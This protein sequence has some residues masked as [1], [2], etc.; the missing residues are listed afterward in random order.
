M[1][2]VV[3]SSF[4]AP[5]MNQSGEVTPKESLSLSSASFTFSLIPLSFSVLS[6]VSL[7]H[8]VSP[9]HRMTQMFRTVSRTYPASERLTALYLLVHPRFLILYVIPCVLLEYIIHSFDSFYLCGLAVRSLSRKFELKVRV[10]Q[11]FFCTMRSLLYRYELTAGLRGE[12]EL[13]WSSTSPI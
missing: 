3:I 7:P 2:D 9:T 13:N 11:L 8:I 6:Y 10:R 1:A 12:E 4:L 5:G